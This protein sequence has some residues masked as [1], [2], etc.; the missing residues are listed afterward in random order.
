MSDAGVALPSLQHDCGACSALCCVMLPFD[1]AQGFGFDKEAGT[2]CQHLQPDFTCG[3]HDRLRDEGFTGCTHYSCHG[4]GQRV[5]KLLGEENWRS[6]DARAAEI[7]SVFARMHRLHELQSLL[8]TARARVASDEWQQRLLQ[9]QQRLEAL[10]LQVEQQEPVDLAVAGS[11][12]L[13]LLRQ[14]ATE[15][16]IVALRNRPT[17]A[18][19]HQP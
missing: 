12:T 9:Q 7:H 4:A 14:L 5:T 6:N 19:R 17:T 1:A 16:A 3:I 15:P 11:E 8:Q 10:C 18:P 2:P 13:N